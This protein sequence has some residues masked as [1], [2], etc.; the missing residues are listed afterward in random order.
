LNSGDTVTLVRNM[1]LE[2]EVDFAALSTFDGDA[3]DIQLERFMMIDQQ[4]STNMDNVFL[5]YP[6]N[7]NFS[8]VNGL[9]QVELLEEGQVWKRVSNAIVG[10]TLAEESGC[11]SL[12]SELASQVMG[13]SGTTLVGAYGPIGTGQTLQAELDAIN[14]TFLG[15][16][17]NLCPVGAI[18]ILPTTTTTIANGW[19]ALPSTA[20][21]AGNATIGNASSGANVRANA[22]ATYLF[23]AL[24]DN[25]SDA[26]CPVSTGRGASAA[27]DFAANKTIGLPAM[28]DRSVIVAG[29]TY[30]V[31]QQAGATTVT[32]V[33]ANIPEMTGTPTGLGAGAYWG[34]FTP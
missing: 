8:S 3:L 26:V 10:V 31:G 15:Y 28:V 21:T 34:G 19:L 13:G 17:N 1:T 11:S 4:F 32:L 7:V 9:N 16:L 25:Y 6:I 23:A 27:A 29:N 14:T 12:R 20:T 30:T 2:L 5:Q 33:A 24:W 18:N 22:D